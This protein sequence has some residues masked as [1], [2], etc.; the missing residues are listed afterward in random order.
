ME[1]TARAAAES[2]SQQARADLADRQKR[3]VDLQSELQQAHA[4]ELAALQ[5]G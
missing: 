4:Q 1:R 2:V 5:V 3:I